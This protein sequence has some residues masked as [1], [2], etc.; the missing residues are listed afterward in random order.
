MSSVG[1]SY[2]RKMRVLE[3][4]VRFL[5]DRIGARENGTHPGQMRPKQ[6]DRDK[7]ELSALVL[8]IDVVKRN[9][10]DALEIIALNR[11]AEPAWEPS[12]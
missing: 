11:R 9:K 1:V 7:A 2:T 5:Q 3:R 4:R 8:A 12:A 10:N 6:I